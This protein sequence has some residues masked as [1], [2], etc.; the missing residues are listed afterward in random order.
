[1][2]V[3]KSG[4]VLGE[5]ISAIRKS[6]GLSQEA[7][8]EKSNV[9]LSTIQRIEKGI[10]NPR[11]FTLKTLADTLELNLSE[12]IPID[13]ETQ[14][15]ITKKS[16]LKRINLS[17]IVFAFIPLINL[18]VPSIVWRM[19]KNVNSGNAIAGKII[20]F[21]LL[22]SILT[23]VMIILSLSL[24]NL[25]IGNAGDGLYVVMIIYTLSIFFN[26]FTIARTSSQLNRDNKNILSF[27]PNLF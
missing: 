21:Q 2:Q 23:I 3:D 15:T 4:I 12:L 1:M 27:V 26:I 7:L 13:S 5:K 9:S 18:I 16:S 20:S 8:A 19:D 22:W 6:K 10:V 17:A 25:I 24:S 11:P 14:H